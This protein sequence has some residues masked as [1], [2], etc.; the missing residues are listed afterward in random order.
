MLAQIKPESDIVYS[1][2]CT[3]TSL[4]HGLVQKAINF[5]VAA[6]HLSSAMESFQFQ[7]YVKS[8]ENSGAE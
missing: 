6:D 1:L 3:P 4:C 8:N 2:P 7:Q 5:P